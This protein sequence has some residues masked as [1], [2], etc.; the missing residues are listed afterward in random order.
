MVKTT[1]PAAPVANAP[2]ASQDTLKTV[3]KFIVIAVCL[4]FVVFV[5][6]KIYRDNYLQQNIAWPPEIHK[7]PDY[8]VYDKSDGKCHEQGGDGVT[9]P[10]GKNS[11]NE[12]LIKL[13]EKMK[14]NNTAW[15][16]IDKL[17]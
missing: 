7:C 15:E 4:V 14:E 3:V 9:D 16:G 8:W 1:T 17:C 2:A 11:T 10:I 5:I 13:C 6:W 12:D